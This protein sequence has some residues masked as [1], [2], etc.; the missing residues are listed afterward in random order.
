MSY[1]RDIA[2]RIRSTVPRELVP[3]DAD[4]LFLIYAVLGKAKGAAVTGRDVHD[5]WT[6]WMEMRGEDHESMVPFESLPASVRAEDSP[7]VVAIRAACPEHRG[8]EA[9]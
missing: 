9:Q 7:F 1:L 5:A 8:D 3:D 2:D 6:A 4:D